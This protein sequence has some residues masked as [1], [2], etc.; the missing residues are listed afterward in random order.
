MDNNSNRKKTPTFQNN[1][2]VDSIRYNSSPVINADNLFIFDLNK[3]TNLSEDKSGINE[4]LNNKA[5]VTSVKKSNVADDT[6][7]ASG[8]G[9]RRLRWQVRC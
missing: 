5:R 2:T 6:A 9:R 7:Y 1:N 8:I 3:Y 4:S